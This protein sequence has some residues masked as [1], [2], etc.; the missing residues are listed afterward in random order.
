MV[1]GFAGSSPATPVWGGEISAP[2]LGVAL[3]A[4]DEEG[5]P[6]L[7]EVGELV[8]IKPMPSMPV[9]F[10]NDPDGWRYREAYFSTYPGVWRHGDWMR[11]TPRGSLIVSG[12][13]DSTLNRHGVRLGSADIYAVVDKIPEVTESLVIGAEL[14]D[15]GY[16]LPLFV[17]LAEGVAL[18]GE[19]VTHITTAIR[20]GAS[21]RHVPD[22]VIAVPAIPHTRTGKKLEIPVKRLIQGHPLDKVASPDAVDDLPALASFRAF[23]QPRNSE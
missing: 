7:D 18:D 9:K 3:E 8:V 13:S 23:R 15:G 14:G 22:D 17:V 16:W 20:N 10:W 19:L 4:W 2:N 1:A 12:R 5:R 6:V 11:V 21:P